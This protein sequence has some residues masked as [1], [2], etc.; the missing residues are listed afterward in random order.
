MQMSQCLK[1]FQTDQGYLVFQRDPQTDLQQCDFVLQT[2]AELANK[3]SPWALSLADGQTIGVAMM[4]CLAIAF[5]VRMMVRA[6][7][8]KETDDVQ[9]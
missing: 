3:P 7:N 4:V 2:G 1:A 8:V 5:V 9:S 6:L